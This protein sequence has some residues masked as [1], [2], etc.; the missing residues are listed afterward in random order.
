MS[1]GAFEARSDWAIRR[2]RPED[3]ELLR[4]VRLAALEESPHAFGE[5]WEGARA[6]DWQARAV[7][8]AS[9]ADRA[10]FLAVN[11]ERPIGMVFVK[12]GIP[13]APAFV[14]GMWVD[15]AFR[16]RGVGR[17]LLEQGITFL[18]LAGQRELSLWVTRG[19]EGVVAF[20]RGLGFRPNGVTSPLRAGSDLLIDEL[21]YSVPASAVTFE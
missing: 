9:Y 8:G 18:R 14:G 5:T 7:D 3:A 12:C 19:H 15:P 1:A 11:P 2:L 17:A 20:Y 10:V 16:R 13:P 21:R 6:A 4:E